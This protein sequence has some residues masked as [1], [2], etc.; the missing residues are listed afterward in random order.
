MSCS[1]AARGTVEVEVRLGRLLEQ[2]LGLVAH[3][4]D[5]AAQV[6][7]ELVAVDPPCRLA[8][9]DAEVG[10]AL[11]VGEDLDRRHDGAQVDGDR[12]PAGR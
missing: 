3:L 6:R 2:R 11:D 10:G 8:D 7:I 5:D 9:V 1:A 4:L 12:A